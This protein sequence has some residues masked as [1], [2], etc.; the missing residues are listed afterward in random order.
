MELFLV[1]RI[2]YLILNQRE[3]L[4]EF[5]FILR[6]LSF[7]LSLLDLYF[8]FSENYVKTAKKYL[9]SGLTKGPVLLRMEISTCCSNIEEL[10]ESFQEVLKQIRDNYER[11]QVCYICTRKSARNKSES[12]L[13]KA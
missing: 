9:Y 7:V 8:Y 11:K 1:V 2:E 5:Q 13:T 10:L 6:S 4:Y 12:F 3:V